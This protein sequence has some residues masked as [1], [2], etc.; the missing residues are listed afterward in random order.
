MIV[1]ITRQE[2][3]DD[4][5]PVQRVCC[6]G[7]SSELEDGSGAVRDDRIEEPRPFGEC[8]RLGDIFEQKEPRLVGR[9]V[10]PVEANVLA[11]DGRAQANGIALGRRQVDDRVA[12]KG[13]GNGRELGALFAAHL[14][15][16]GEVFPALKTKARDDM[17][18]LGAGPI[19]EEDVERL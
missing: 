15:R 19:G 14:D 2:T 3:I 9:R 4:Q 18:H 5:S 6:T 8:V 17:R 13:V 7:S 1:E 11:P 12:T 10:E 16:P